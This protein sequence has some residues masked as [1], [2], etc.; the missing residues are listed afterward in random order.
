MKEQDFIRQVQ[1][2]AALSSRED[3]MEWSKA[4][5]SALADLAPDSETRRQFITQLPGFL[6]SHLQAE[7]RRSLVMDREALIQHVAATLDVHAPDARRALLAVWDVVRK[8]VSAGELADF[9]AQVPQ[10]VA[11]F[12]RTAA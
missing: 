5:T 7:T 3:A 12:L 1:A 2:A 10:D 9:E 4:V 8:A 6:K 11:T